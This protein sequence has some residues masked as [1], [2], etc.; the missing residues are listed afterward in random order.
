MKKIL[1]ICAVAISV[2]TAAALILSAYGGCANPLNG[3]IPA[4]MNLMLPAIALFSFLLLVTFAFFARKTAIIIAAAFV[5]CAP[6]LFN[7]CPLNIF[8]SVP[9]NE[10]T[11]TVMTYNV[12]NLTD[13]TNPASDC[14]T[15]PT[16][17]SILTERPD[18][19]ALQ[20]CRTFEQS[21]SAGVDAAMLDSLYNLYP[22]RTNGAEGQ[23]LL[24]KF[25]FDEL[26]LHF[27]PTHEFQVRT[28]RINAPT[29]TFTLFNLH[30]KSIGLTDS[31]KEL[32]KD[33]TK[34]KTETNSIRSELR[35]I[36]HDLLSKLAAAFRERAVQA[37]KVKE[38]VDSIGGKVIVCGDFN[39]APGCY[40]IREIKSAGLEDAYRHSATGPCITYH[41]DR[42]YFRIDHILYRGFTP[43]KTACPKIPYSDHYPLVT[44]FV[45]KN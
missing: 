32:Y 34:G 27:N 35:G 21:S 26:K 16:L 6:P 9:D 45:H 3:V 2:I 39:D 24:S 42:F 8:H 18:I 38:L 1:K 25:P 44:T 28:Y 40:A 7:L 4:L 37:Q 17:A 13:F 14:T 23:A 19:A 41:A 31:D 5:I 22:Y 33:L 12:C 11:F 10:K 29:D 30:L 43:V 15:N 20:E 36:K